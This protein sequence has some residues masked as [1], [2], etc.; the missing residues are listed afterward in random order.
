[1]DCYKCNKSM[2]KLNQLLINGTFS[3]TFNEAYYDIEC[4][5]SNYDDLNLCILKSQNDYA[6]SITGIQMCDKPE[7][8]YEKLISYNYFI[9][10]INHGDTD[11]DEKNL[12]FN[13]LKIG[14]INQINK[15]IK[16]FRDILLN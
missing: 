12:D 9:Y 13:H 4:K 2:L 1:M 16:I 6:S 10:Y 3:Y 7:V 14:D 5:I 11:L 8:V 15:N